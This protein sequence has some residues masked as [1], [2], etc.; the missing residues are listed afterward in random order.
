M[1]LY[2]ITVGIDKDIE[3]EWL[4]WMKEY[5]LPKVMQVGAFTDYKMYKVL[6]H[7]DENSV[8]YSI[9]YFSDAIEKIVSYLNNDGKI[10]MEEHRAKFK[11]KHVVFNTLLEEQ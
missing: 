11:D 4:V 5:H 3:Q 10:L 1:L 8:S 6:S 2:N 7:D 9:Q